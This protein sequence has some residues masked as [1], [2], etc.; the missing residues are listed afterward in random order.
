MELDLNK[1]RGESEGSNE[2]FHGNIRV[3]KTKKAA[4]FEL[5]F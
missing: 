1:S 4:L 2:G 5:L 3:L